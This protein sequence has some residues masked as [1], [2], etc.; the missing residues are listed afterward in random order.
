MLKKAVILLFL[1]MLGMLLFASSCA[2]AE[3]NASDEM[4]LNEMYIAFLE[5]AVYGANS[6]DVSLTEP[7][8]SVPIDLLSVLNSVP[9]KYLPENQN[10]LYEYAYVLRYGIEDGL[11]SKQQAIFLMKYAIEKQVFASNDSVT[12]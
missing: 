11:V 10:S 3:N 9:D 12:F 4:S 8:D 5:E 7:D 1:A 2:L 6:R